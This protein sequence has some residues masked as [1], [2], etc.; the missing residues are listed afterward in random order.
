MS[1]LG[2]PVC[3]WED[4]VVQLRWP[5][6]AG[7]ANKASLIEG[8][9]DFQRIGACEQSALRHV[10]PANHDEPLEQSWRPIDPT[11]DRFEPRERQPRRDRPRTVPRPVSAVV[12][13]V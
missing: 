3:F 12:S 9:Q 6:W 2:C 8:Q 10:R 13:T 11:H 5:D 1:P 7:G 4:D